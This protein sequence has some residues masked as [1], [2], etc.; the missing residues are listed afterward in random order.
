M[1]FNRQWADLPTSLSDVVV[2]GKVCRVVVHV[3]VRSNS[4]KTPTQVARLLIR[5]PWVWIMPEPHIGFVISLSTVTA[6]IWNSFQSTELGD[7]ILT[8]MRLLTA[9]RPVQAP[10]SISWQQGG[11]PLY[12]QREYRRFHSRRRKATFDTTAWVAVS[13]FRHTTYDL[14]EVPPGR[15]ATWMVN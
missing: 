8:W 12:F 7:M 13:F 9:A 1:V 14:P 4:L 3:R 10:I 6:D 5:T 11:V 15:L 2:T